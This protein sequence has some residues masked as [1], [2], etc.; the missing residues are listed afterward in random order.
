M[1]A[2]LV[3]KTANYRIYKLS[4]PIRI[5]KSDI[6]GEVNIKE[7]FEELKK[8]VREDSPHYNEIIE[9]LGRECT[10][11]MISDARTH[12]ERLV[13][14]AFEYNG[15]YGWGS[16]DIGGKHT[17]MIYGGDQNSIYP[18]EVYLR[19]L[20]QINKLKWEGIK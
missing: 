9:T 5:G 16:G 18:D 4:E 11:V 7:A 8:R 10:F 20:A 2:K 1:E 12:I 19:R 15:K 6:C 13:F 3:N 17:M 14:P